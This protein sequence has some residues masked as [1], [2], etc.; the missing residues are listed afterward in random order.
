M[1]NILPYDHARD[2]KAVRRIH[3]EVGWLS[4]GAEAK[5]FEKMVPHLDGVVY[6]ID[7]EAEC[8]VFTCPGAMRYLAEDVEMCAV[9]AVTTS[10]IARKLGAAKQLTAHALA[11]AA[12]AGNEIAT[13]GMFEQGFYDQLGFGTGAYARAMRFDPA[14]LTVNTPFR[15]PTRLGRK[16]WRR[17]HEALHRRMRGHGGCVLDVPQIVRAEM[18]HDNLIALGYCDGPNGELTHFLWG[19]AKDQHGPYKIYAYAYQN[20]DQLFELLALLKSLGDQVTSLAMEEP[21]EIQLQDLLKQ[22]FRNRGMTQG[23]EHAAYHRT[24]AYWQARIL[25]LPKCL[26]KTRLDAE[27]VRFNLQLTDPITTHLAGSNAWQ[28]VAGDYVV[29]LGEESA[30]ERAQSAS[31]PTLTASVGAFTRMWLGVRNPS[32]LALTDDLRGDETL[33]ASLDRA[34]RLPQPHFGWDF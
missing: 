9:L 19:E 27:T 22:P 15:R 28:G 16:D 30:A 18:A 32:S 24:T 14:T 6:P 7:G 12:E 13:L 34:L 8:A 1:P 5:A 10:R 31:L 29:T 23:S 3:Y 11:T 20:T 26:A 17:M 33:L 21:P 2:F 4:S 25:D